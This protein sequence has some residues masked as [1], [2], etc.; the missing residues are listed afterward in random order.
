MLLLLGV[1]LYRGNGGF[2]QNACVRV[3]AVSCGNFMGYTLQIYSK[4]KLSVLAA[5]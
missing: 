3:Y 5:A 4:I 2:T 1:I